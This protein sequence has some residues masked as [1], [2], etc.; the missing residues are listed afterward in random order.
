MCRSLEGLI[1][2]TAD[3]LGLIKL[4]RYPAYAEEA[5]FN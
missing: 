4:H 1:L 5:K 2:A 3:Y